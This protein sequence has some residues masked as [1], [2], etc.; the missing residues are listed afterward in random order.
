M[1]LPYSLLTLAMVFSTCTVFALP[2]PAPQATPAPGAMCFDDGD[3]LLSGGGTCNKTAGQLLGVCKPAAAG[4]APAPNPFQAIPGLAA[5]VASSSTSRA[6]AAS[7]P[8]GGAAPKASNAGAGGASKPSTA[9]SPSGTGAVCFDAGD[10]ILSG[11]GQ[12]NKAAG[13]LTGQCSK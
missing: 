13:Q 2:E 4:A 10:C 11:G 12:C 3:C 6:T 5:P 9:P 1:Q 8:A 7:R